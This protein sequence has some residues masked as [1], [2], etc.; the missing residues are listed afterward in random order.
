MSVCPPFF[1]WNIEQLGK[2]GDEA[3]ARK[4]PGARRLVGLVERL[5]GLSTQ[6]RGTFADLQRYCVVRR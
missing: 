1:D 2:I 6:A 4:V 3:V 5:T